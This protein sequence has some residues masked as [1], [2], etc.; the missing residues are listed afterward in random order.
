[1]S[2]RQFIFWSIILFLFPPLFIGCEEKDFTFNELIDEM[3]SVYVGVQYQG[4]NEIYESEEVT[5]SN[6]S[7]SI[8]LVNGRFQDSL[9]VKIKSIDYSD[10]SITAEGDQIEYLFFSA[11]H[12]KLSFRRYLTSHI[13]YTFEGYKK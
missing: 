1:M 3:N 4:P 5:L 7:D 13:L 6:E 11:K 2:K 8:I 12:D 9:L 10:G